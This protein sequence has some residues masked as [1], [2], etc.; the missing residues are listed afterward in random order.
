ML[1]TVVEGR[2]VGRMLGFPTANLVFQKKTQMPSKGVY[3]VEVH[4][5]NEI[6]CGVMNV[7]C[8]PTFGTSDIVAEVHILDFAR[9]I[10]GETLDIVVRKLIRKERCF[11]SPEALKKQIENDRVEAKKILEANG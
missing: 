11:P 2:K 5:K 7:G 1:A 10:Y 8:R 4:L 6:F 9:D 3:A